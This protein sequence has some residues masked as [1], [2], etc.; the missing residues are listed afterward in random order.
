[1]IFRIMMGEQKKRINVRGIVEVKFI[2]FVYLFKIII[3]VD[4]GE[5]GVEDSFK[6]FS[7]CNWEK[8]DIIKSSKNILWRSQFSDGEVDLF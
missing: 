2:G 3:I 1:M 7:L 6:V 4:I 8:V 5:Q